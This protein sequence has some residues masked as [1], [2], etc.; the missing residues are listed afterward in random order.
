MLIE[1][2]FTKDQTYRHQQ[3]DNRPPIM[4]AEKV[5]LW[6]GQKQA[7]KDISLKI[8]ETGIL[9]FIGPSGCGKTTMLKCL[10][11]MHDDTRDVTITGEMYYDGINIM[12]ESIDPPEYRKQFGWVAQRPNPFAMTIW[13]NVAYGPR[14]HSVC[15]QGEFQAHIQNCLE[16]AYLWD[17]VKNRLHTTYGID[18]S[19]GQ[20]QRLCIARALSTKP[21][22][23]LMDEPT[24][25]IDPVAT[26]QIEDLIL[27]LA[28]DHAIVI[29]TH[30]MMQARRISDQVGYFHMGE[31]VEIGPTKEVFE[32][33][34][35]P[36]TAAFIHGA[37]G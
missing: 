17:E 27:E 5:N 28:Q 10:N 13:D 22:I 9:A 35:D 3:V 24:G 32:A 11:R 25:S 21:R 1:Q 2:S 16:R 33:P 31:L 8:P 23:L 18:L 30:S 4:T 7:L 36:R 26:A 34:Q 37:V 29:I 19:I 6:Y 12:D 15:D 20:Q 14:I